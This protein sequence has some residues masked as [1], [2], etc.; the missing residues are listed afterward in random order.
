MIYDG[1]VN[2]RSREC[3]LQLEI[4]RYHVVYLVFVAPARLRGRPINKSAE[5]RLKIAHER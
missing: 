3:K 1:K 4:L 2:R 5:C